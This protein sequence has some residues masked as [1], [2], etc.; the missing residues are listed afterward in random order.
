MVTNDNKM[1][2]KSREKSRKIFSCA[3]CDYTTT[4]PSDFKKHLSTDKHNDNQMVTKVAKSREKSRDDHICECGKIYKFKSGLSRHKKICIAGENV[5]ISKSDENE[6][7]GNKDLVM[8]LIKENHELRDMMLEEH[9]TAQSMMMDV[10]RNGTHNTTTNSHNK[11]FNLQLFLNE[12][13]KDAMNIMDFVESLKLQ[14]NDLEAM[15]DIG[16]VNGMTDIIVK[17]LKAI[18]IYKRPIHS[19]DSKR[20]V[21]YVKDENKWEKDYEDKSRLKKAIKHIAHKNSKLLQD[22]REK[23][24]DCMNSDS[25]HNGEYSRLVMAVYDG[26][27]EN[28]NKIIKKISKEVSIDKI[29]GGN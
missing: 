13:C 23:Y 7:D 11:T 29:E 1:I 12:Q 22:F 6:D 19:S 16:Y 24:P 5:I 17:N 20:E 3:V 2:T 10:I 14:L 15:G 4:K 25:K 21:I 27:D 9:K 8:M 26:T 18:D 28:E